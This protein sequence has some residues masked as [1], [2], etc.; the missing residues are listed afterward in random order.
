MVTRTIIAIMGPTAS[1]KTDLA[2]ELARKLDTQL[3]S[4]DSAMVYRGL[5]IGTAKP[6]PSVLE[7]FPHALIDIR[8][9]EED[10]SV[11][12]FFD[13][14]NQWVSQ[15]LKQA[16]T[17]VLVGGSMMYFNAFKHGLTELPSRDASVRAEL[18]QERSRY[19]LQHMH[20]LLTKIDPQSAQNIH[21]RNWVR[22]ERALEVYRLAGE[23]MSSLWR[24][25]PTQTATERHG[26][27]LQE[28]ALTAIP[29]ARLHE[30]I[31]QRLD[32]MIANGLWDEIHH[33]RQRPRLT[34]DALSMQAVGYK[35]AWTQLEHR[36]GDDLHAEV[37]EQILFAS[38]QLARRQLVW[39]RRWRGLTEEH[40]LPCDP[41][42]ES[43]LKLLNHSDPNYNG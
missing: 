19:G 36:A 8:D 13:D 11:R 27:T 40:V 5:D 32:R 26:C 24:K 25:K 2:L 31:E 10:Y 15:T 39:L 35:Q 6:T 41:P 18:N 23:P 14:A 33:L 21:P 29:R 9:P 16:K 28:F 37:R 34:Q 17:P 20:E 12:E 1:G 30:R 7:S 22:I 38:R 3:I 4:V 43:L 42:V